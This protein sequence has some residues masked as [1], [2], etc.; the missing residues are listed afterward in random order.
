MFRLTICYRRITCITVRRLWTSHPAIRSVVHCECEGL[1]GLLEWLDENTHRHQRRTTYRSG[2]AAPDP[3]GRVGWWCGATAIR[4]RQQLWHRGIQ[5]GFSVIPPG[6]PVSQRSE[7]STKISLNS[8]HFLEFENLFVLNWNRNRFW[9]TRILVYFC[10]TLIGS[11]V[12]LC[13]CMY[14][15]MYVCIL[16]W[17]LSF[18]SFIR[19]EQHMQYVSNYVIHDRTTGQLRLQLPRNIMKAPLYTNNS[20]YTQALKRLTAHQR[21]LGH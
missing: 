4:E 17:L 21:S 14:V 15:C 6:R 2:A 5:T 7:I 16:S 19:Q 20:I 9:I 3:K 13:I 18:I 8:G 12:R 11:R 1:H 10:L